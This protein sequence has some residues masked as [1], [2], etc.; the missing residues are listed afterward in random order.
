MET[1]QHVV[2]KLLVSLLIGSQV[3]R[4]DE[5]HLHEHEPKTDTTVWER[6]VLRVASTSADVIPYDLGRDA[7]PATL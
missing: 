1:N 2:T 4:H 7:P 3:R 5:E 6:H